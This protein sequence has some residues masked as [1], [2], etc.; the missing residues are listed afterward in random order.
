MPIVAEK[1]LLERKTLDLAHIVKVRSS[2]FMSEQLLAAH[3]RSF[4]P[5]TKEY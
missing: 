5:E 3:I 4:L 1:H 2:D